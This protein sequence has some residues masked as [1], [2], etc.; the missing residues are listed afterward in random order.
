MNEEARHQWRET[1]SRPLDQETFHP[2]SAGFALEVAAA[3]YGGKWPPHN[4]DHYLA[5]RAG[6]MQETIATSLAATDLPPA[7]EEYSY[8]LC[9][10][11]GLGEQ[12]A[13]TRAS[14]VALSALAHLGLR[15]GKWNLR[16]SAENLSEIAAQ[17]EFF[18]RQVNDIVRKASGAD[19]ELADMATSLTAL[20]VAEGDLF[21]W[22]VGHSRAY[23]FRRGVLTQLTMDHTLAES[24]HDARKPATSAK[25]DFIH[26][27]TETVG[28][29]PCG[30]SIDAEHIKLS[31]GD[32]LLLCTNG[33]SDV[34]SNDQ[35]ADQLAQFRSPAEDCRQ[36]IDL[37]KAAGSP[38]DVTV[39]LADYSVH[40]DRSTARAAS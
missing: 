39:M 37:A 8:A 36:L 19:V 10:A 16:V 26:L 2:L 7:F 24:G 27:V 28:G 4:T 31:S 22:H 11:D 29:R 35:I 40:S 14:R 21:F 25:S 20:Y 9:I 18:Y 12:G 33:L 6:R 23:L 17:G 32:R 1:V 3:S 30:P 34:V 13:G 38:D 15:Y 5:V